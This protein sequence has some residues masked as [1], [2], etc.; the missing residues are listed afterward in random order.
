MNIDIFSDPV[1]P[2]CFIGRRRLA[3]ALDADGT[4]AELRWRVFQL[5]PDMPEEGMDRAEYLAAKFGGS[6]RARELYARVAEAGES[7]GI[8]FAFD[9]IART[10]N[11]LD[12]HRLIKLAQLLGAQNLVVDGL[13]DAYFLE[14]RDIGEHEELVAIAEAAGLDPEQAR[15]FLA[16]EAGRAE[17]LK[18]DA[19]ARRMQIGGVPFFILD[20]RLA[21]NG[22][23]PPEV[24]V[25]A[26]DRARTMQAEAG[27]RS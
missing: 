20:G 19:S 7:V 1:C 18:E 22:A 13:F 27:I 24:F 4:V 9:R 11:T 16:S 23:Q 2:W 17:V 12:A 15:D 26:L 8:D 5:N 6:E 3:A 21:V 10:P 25:A 14:G